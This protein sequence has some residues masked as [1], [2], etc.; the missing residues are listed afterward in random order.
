MPE[1]I[2]AEYNIVTPMFIGDVNQKA[3]GIS[4]AS[5]KGVLRFWWRA[6]NWGLYRN[7][8]DKISDQTALHELHQEESFLFGSAAEHGT[9]Q[10]RFNIRIKTRN[11][12]PPKDDW[13]KSDSDSGYLGIGLWQSGKK[14]KGNF[15]AARQYIG[16]KTKFTI[17]AVIHPSLSEGHIQSLKDAFI[18]FGLLG[19]LGSRS[20]R[21]FGSVALLKLDNDNYKFNSI[22]QYKDAIHTMLVSY[23]LPNTQPPY[24]AFSQAS[25]IRI[26]SKP[27]STARLAHAE[28]GH[29]FK[30]HRGEPSGLRGIQKRVFGMPYSGGGQ[31]EKDA[32]RAS[33]LLM[34]IHQIQDNYYSVATALPA[35]FH[36]EKELKK[37]DYN[38]ILSFFNQFEEVPLS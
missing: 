24:T 8:K 16:E 20:R 19:G 15:Q 28:L 4:P 25:K 9:G 26:N 11:M 1:S 12:P 14:E 37:V 6:L 27:K 23:D 3:T 29:L 34:H 30:L 17:E 7:G 21:A 10:S 36:H 18:I 22:Q 35:L 38:L 33:P 32:R 2:K 13:P 31:K 5:V